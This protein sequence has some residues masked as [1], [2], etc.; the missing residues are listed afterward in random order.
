MKLLLAILLLA[1]LSSAETLILK[2]AWLENFKDRATIDATF[3]IDHAHKKANAASADG[4]MHVAGRAP[5]EVGLPMVAEMMNAAGTLQKA[6]VNLIHANEGKPTSAPINGAWR[7]WFEHPAP[8]QKQF[9]PVA[10]ASNT[11]PDHSF[12]IHPILKYGGLD[13][14]GSVDFV[15]GFPAH[16]AKASF[17]SYEKMTVALKATATAVTMDAKKSGF[18]YA[19]YRMRILGKPKK[20]DDG[21]LAVLADVFDAKDEETA[22]ASKVRMIF[23]P[24]TGPWKTVGSDGDDGSTYDAMGIPRVNLNAISTFLKAAGTASATRKLPYEMIVVALKEVE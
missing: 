21:G 14:S 10:V 24:G 23:L 16:D 6:A 22:L 15:K 3:F 11:N 1:G 9:D 2:R 20:L 12:E 19:V 5:K 8:L 4:D 13:V 17:A 7:L 18:N